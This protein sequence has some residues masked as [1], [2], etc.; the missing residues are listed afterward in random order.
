MM[1]PLQLDAVR[2]WVLPAI[3]AAS[4][5]ALFY[6]V[7]AW[8]TIDGGRLDFLEEE[9]ARTLDLDRRMH[10]VN[11]R[12]TAKERI[13]GELVDGKTTLREAA[14]QFRFLDQLPPA[15]LRT[16]LIVA[17]EGRSEEELHCLAVI[18]WV[19]E[20]QA[21]VDSCLVEPVCRQL[22]AELDRL[23][24]QGPLHLPDV[25]P[26]YPEEIEELRRSFALQKGSRAGG[27]P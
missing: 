20:N 16:M 15:C 23:L 26:S 5:A 6:A 1:L 19:R 4:L 2:R 22:Q 25:R 21:A 7:V 11:A 17:P 10:V 12:V 24:Q 3:V 13:V 8:R 27:G 18:W 14:G 9:C